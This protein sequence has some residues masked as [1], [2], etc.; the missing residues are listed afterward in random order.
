MATAK[1]FLLEWDISLKEKYLSFDKEKRIRRM[2]FFERMLIPWILLALI[3]I[4]LPSLILWFTFGGLNTLKIMFYFSAS[5][6]IIYTLLAIKYYPVVI[7]KRT[8]DFW[9]EWKIETYILL[10]GIIITNIYSIYIQYLAS[11]MDFQWIMNMMQYSSILN[12]IQW[13][14]TILWLYLLFRPWTKWT[15]DYWEQKYYKLKFL[16]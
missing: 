2:Q 3:I 9:K 15:N 11:N 6:Y 13:I 16:G 7:K 10:W 8:Q 12:I 14:L 1:E 4:I 5:F